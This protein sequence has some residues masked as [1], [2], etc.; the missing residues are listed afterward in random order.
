MLGGGNV[1]THLEDDLFGLDLQ[2]LGEKRGIE[3]HHEEIE[4]SRH[5]FRVSSAIGHAL[6]MHLSEPVS[7]KGFF[8]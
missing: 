8:G 2:L 5:D 1:G 3:P 7:D 6:G 4:A